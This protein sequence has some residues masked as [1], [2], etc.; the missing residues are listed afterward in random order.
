MTTRLGVAESKLARLYA[1]SEAIVEAMYD[2]TK[3]THGSPVNDKRGADAWMKRNRQLDDR[4]SAKNDEIRAQ[5]ARVEKLK[6][7]EENYRLGLNKNGN[8]VRLAPDNVD[9]IKEEILK[10]ERGES[11]YGRKTIRGY[12]DYLKSLANQTEPK[13]SELAKKVIASG[14]VTQ[15]AKHPHIYFVNGMRKV[16]IELDADGVFSISMRYYPYDPSDRELVENLIR[17]NF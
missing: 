8:G 9:R 15:W 2:H 6:W 16:A 1:E 5:E 12:I 3:I 14:R 11:H 13:I 4:L 17:G 7:Q 10:A